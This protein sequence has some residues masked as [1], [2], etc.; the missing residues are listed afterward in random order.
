M[1]EVLRVYSLLYLI[2]LLGKYIPNKIFIET[3]Y[4]SNLLDKTIYVET[5]FKK[6]V[7]II[8]GICKNI[9]YDVLDIVY[10][11]YLSSSIGKE[12][13]ILKYLYHGFLIG[14]Q[15]NTM[16]SL[17]YVF[18]VNS[19]RK[20]VSFEAH[21]LKGLLRFISIEDTFYATIHPD[22]NIIEQVGKHF[23]KRLPD[24]NFIIID[25][26]RKIA[27]IYNKYHYH[28]L[29]VKELNIPP[30]SKE[31]KQYQDL[32]KVFWKTIAI[33]ERTN[34]RLQAQYMPRR[35]WKDLIEMN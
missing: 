15:I 16:L 1:T 29:D 4:Q 25:Q 26:F 10:W 2:A 23:I 13:N 27:F 31:E 12:L 32:W 21:R 35:Y 22:H 28:L 9:S 5:D 17:D 3:T 33:K 20:K 19:L 11:A 14:S 30:I 34:P 24:Q 7:R 8:N 18:E 6:S